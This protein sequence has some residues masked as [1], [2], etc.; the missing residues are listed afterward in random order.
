MT[1]Y[2]PSSPLTRGRLAIISSAEP[3][4]ASGEPAT[5]ATKVEP[6]RS[7]I[8]R[9]FVTVTPLSSR[10]SLYNTTLLTVRQSVRTVLKPTNDTFSRH[11][12]RGMEGKANEPS[13]S[14]TQ[15]DI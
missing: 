7:T 10:E 1:L 6:R 5:L 9:L 15:P 3:I 4:C 14:V 12:S 11:C 13:A 2:L 8:E